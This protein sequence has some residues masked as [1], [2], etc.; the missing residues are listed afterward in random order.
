MM[1]L[2]RTLSAQELEGE[3]KSPNLLR[4][5]PASGS[6]DPDGIE[7]LWAP[8]DYVNPKA[9]LL[10]VGVTPGPEQAIRSYRAVRDA[11]A[12]GLDPQN[13]LEKIKAE[14]SFRGKVIE[15]NLMS[16]LEHSGVAERVGIDNIDLLWTDEAPKVHFTSTIRYPTF[17]HGALYNNQIDS[18]PIEN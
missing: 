10:I 3:V 11:F 1:E 18:R 5:Y 15:P 16:L 13:N 8:F 9:R 7:I 17:I 12:K 6:V 14:A 4:K 2:L